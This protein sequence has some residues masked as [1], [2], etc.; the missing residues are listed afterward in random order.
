MVRDG[1][2][3]RIQDLLAGG[4]NDAQG[5]YL[6]LTIRL[7][8]RHGDAPADLSL[9]GSEVGGADEIH[10]CRVLLQKAG[11]PAAGFRRVGAVGVGQTESILRAGFETTGNRDL[12]KRFDLRRRW[13]RRWGRNGRRRHDVGA[14]TL[15]RRLV[16]VRVEN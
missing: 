11:A 10:R 6:E 5:T 1:R 12:R 13:Y 9:K 15:R 14:R 4:S 2:A 7:H 3:A 16:G 8:T